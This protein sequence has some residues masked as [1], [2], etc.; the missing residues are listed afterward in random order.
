MS[1]KI[2]RQI[3]LLSFFLAHRFLVTWN[4][5]RD[6]FYGGIDNEETAKRK[7]E[8][9]KEDLRSIGIGIE[10]LDKSVKKEE[11]ETNKTVCPARTEDI[12]ELWDYEIPSH[13]EAATPLNYDGSPR[14]RVIKENFYLPKIPLSI[15]EKMALYF[16]G[17]IVGQEDGFPFKDALKMAVNKLSFDIPWLNDRDEGDAFEKVFTFR[18]GI[19]DVSEKETKKLELLDKAVVNSKKVSFAYYSIYRD[20]ESRRNVDPYGL[21]LHNGVW[22]LV[23]KCHKEGDL[24]IF[25]ISRFKGKAKVNNVKPKTPDFSVPTD[26]NI[27]DFYKRE[28]WDLGVGEVCKIKMKVSPRFSWWMKN[29]WEGGNNFAEQSDGSGI[30]ELEARNIDAF[31]RWVLQ[32]GAEI[33]VLSPQKIRDMMRSKIEKIAENLEA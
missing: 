17:K 9:D 22:Y 1:K 8:R 5:I 12:E 19:K 25:K 21:M 11:L 13:M 28:P 16:L 24:R 23:G 29:K 33:E 18:L 6:E 3:S 31:I 27:R 20:T 7:F 26:F 10:C 4:K 30:L 14:Y 15:N 2:E 32:F